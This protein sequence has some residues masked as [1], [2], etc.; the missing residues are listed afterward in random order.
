MAAKQEQVKIEETVI[1]RITIY[2][3][4]IFVVRDVKK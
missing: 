1:R 3:K 4:W 2:E